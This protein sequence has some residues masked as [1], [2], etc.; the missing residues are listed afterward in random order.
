MFNVTT[1]RRRLTHKN[2]PITSNSLLSVSLEPFTHD[3]EV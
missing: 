2:V 1:H 3:G